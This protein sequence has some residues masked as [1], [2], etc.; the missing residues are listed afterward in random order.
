MDP[1]MVP[2]EK[3]RKK[4]RKREITHLLSCLML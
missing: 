1:R 2:S 4:K 3:A